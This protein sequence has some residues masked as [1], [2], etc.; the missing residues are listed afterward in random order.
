MI[1]WEEART[2]IKW[3]RRRGI[4]NPPFPRGDLRYLH[5][6][7]AQ[8]LEPFIKRGRTMSCLKHLRCLPM[9][10]PLIKPECMKLV[11]SKI[12]LTNPEKQ[13]KFTKIKVQRGNLWDR[14]C[15]PNPTGEEKA[16]EN[17]EAPMQPCISGLPLRLLR[18]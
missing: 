9:V 3:I 5:C 8:L 11:G 14:T 16:G 12:H 15:F 2:D 4:L 1:Q 7:P 17:L 10:D 13:T 18:L 6:R